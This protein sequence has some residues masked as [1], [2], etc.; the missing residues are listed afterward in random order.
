M[1]NLNTLSLSILGL[2]FFMLSSC[3]TQEKAVT[4]SATEEI[5]TVTTENNLVEAKNLYENNCGKCHNLPN[6]SE[7]T[8]EA[9]TP[10]MKSM[11]K[12][13]KL[14]EEQTQWLL[15]YVQQNAK[16]SN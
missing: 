13:S 11:A 1:K 7:Y 4:V 9:W 15:A 3:K 6:P 16:N 10:I 12:K 5:S 2:F 8:K 14:T